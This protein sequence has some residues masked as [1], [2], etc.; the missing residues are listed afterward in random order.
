VIKG[1]NNDFSFSSTSSADCHVSNE[2]I[3]MMITA[4]ENVP[5]LPVMFLTDSKDDSYFSE[6]FQ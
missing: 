4:F 1:Q 2:L 5:V 6:I 3:A